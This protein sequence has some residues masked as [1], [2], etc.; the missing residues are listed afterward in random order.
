MEMIKTFFLKP[1]SF[2]I[3]ISLFFLSCVSHE[4]QMKKAELHHQMALSLMKKCQYPSALS[5][6]NKALKLRK[7]DPVFHHS[8]ALLYFQFKKYGKSVKHLNEALK[9]NPGFTDARVHLGRSLIET[10]KWSQGLKELQKSKEDLTYRYSENIHAHIGLMYYKKKN[11]S[12]A[13]KHLSVARTVKKEDCFTAL[14]HAKSLYFQGQFKKALA[15]LEPSKHWCEKNLPL[16]S[17]PSFDSYFFA[18]L[19][20]NKTGQRQKAFLNLQIFLNKA[21]NSEY[22]DEAKKQMKL[23]KGLN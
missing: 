10:G 8:I 19:A 13:E 18:A 7:E 17:D 14:Y 9:L 2:L 4:K 21:K 12:L 6:L 3:F 15:I 20:Y 5:E 1:V 22:M 23:W 11:F 16:C